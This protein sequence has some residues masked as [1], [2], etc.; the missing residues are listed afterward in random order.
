MKV[1]ISLIGFLL[2]PVVTLAGTGF[3]A[4]EG[5]VTITPN[6]SAT[7]AINFAT[8]NNITMIQ[9]VSPAN[10]WTIISI[11]LRGQSIGGATGSMALSGVATME[12]IQTQMFKGLMGGPSAQGIASGTQQLMTKITGGHSFMLILP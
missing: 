2:L 10:V 9:R 11:P 6:I 12:S 4:F 7:Q 3:I 8:L 5:A 1:T